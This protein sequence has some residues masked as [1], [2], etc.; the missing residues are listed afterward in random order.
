MDRDEI[1]EYLKEIKP[2]FQKKGIEI[3]ALFGSFANGSDNVYSDID[4]AISKNSQFFE[5]F[6]AYDYFDTIN[7]IK[8]NITKK[9]KR[10]VDIFDLDSKSPFLDSIKDSLI[11]V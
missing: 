9:F 7:E 8:S 11:Y 1:I 4:I 10:R 5:K 3:V 6:S 2:N